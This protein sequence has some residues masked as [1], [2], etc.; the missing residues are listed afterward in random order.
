MPQSIYQGLTYIG[1]TI[2]T[3]TDPSWGKAP[4]WNWV[5]G[6]W[7]QLNADIGPVDFGLRN[8]SFDRV[9]LQIFDHKNFDYLD[10]TLTVTGPGVSGTPITLP[11]DTETVWITG[12]TPNSTYTVLLVA[13]LLSGGET[14]DSIQTV[15]T[16]AN[17]TP[18]AVVDLTSPAR[19]NAWI[20]L[21]WTN[22]SGSTAVTYRVYYG[23]ENGT[24]LGIIDTLGLTT[25]RVAGLQ[26]DSKYWYYVRGIN[27]SGKEGPQSNVLRWATGHGEILRQGSDNSVM[28]EPRE[29]GS[30]RPDIEWRW[31]REGGILPRNPH[32]YQGYWPGNNWHGASNPAQ[33]IEA[34]DKRRY[35]GCTV[36]KQ[37]V[38]HDALNA[39]HGSGVA[40]SITISKMSFK[41]LY[42]HVNPGYVEA[43][44]MVWHLTNTNPFNSGKP[45]VYRNFDGQAMR[46]GQKIDG[47]ALPASWGTML[48][49]GLDGG[50][51]VKGLALH[52]KDNQTNGY[53]AAGYGRWSG[54]LLRDPDRSETWRHSNLTLMME[55]SWS[56]VIRSYV[57]PYQWQTGA[58]QT[59]QGLE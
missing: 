23:K 1:E 14:P 22:P 4:V 10:Y 5:E 42:R 17:P 40:D 48:I 36:Y 52:R 19:T 9:M 28:W 34:G 26:E 41:R 37:S 57:G 7:I 39:K 54:H 35:W 51:V 30:Y 58:E 12:L 53:G 43:Q 25:V 3:Y 33:N 6:N 11:D 16:P 20:D 31:A 32:L 46:Q 27:P 2:Q 38:I 47:Y 56:I 55:G 44:D 50:T 45:P 49:R 24:A 59:S 21:S 29:W 18:F 13:N 8:L 15:T